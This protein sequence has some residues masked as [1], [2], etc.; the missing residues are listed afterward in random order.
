MCS[1]RDA[2]CG[3]SGWVRHTEPVESRVKAFEPEALSAFS[4][5]TDLGFAHSTDTPADMER[6]PRSMIIRFSRSE[7]LVEARLALA[8]AGEDTIDTTVRTVDGQQ[9]LG[10]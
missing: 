2:V 3:M 9:Q 1:W 6:R 7:A 8:V 4:F 5:L 10:P